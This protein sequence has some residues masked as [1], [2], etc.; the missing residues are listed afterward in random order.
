MLFFAPRKMIFQILL[1]I[2][3]VVFCISFEKEFCKQYQDISSCDYLIPK[4]PIHFTSTVTRNGVS[5]SQCLN[6]MERFDWPI[7]VFCEGSEFCGFGFH[8]DADFTSVTTSDVAA[9]AEVCRVFIDRRQTSC[10]I[11][12]SSLYENGILRGKKKYFR[13]FNL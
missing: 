13:L 4:S 7:G 10:E 5:Q 2:N 12:K 9:I 8:L 3:F 1:F 11:F 6:A